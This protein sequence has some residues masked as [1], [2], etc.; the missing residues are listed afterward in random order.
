MIT[1]NVVLFGSI[2]GTLLMLAAR[3]SV[4]IGLCGVS[5]FDCRTMLDNIEHATYI[6]PLILLFSLITY[7]L[8]ETAFTTWWKFARIA[9]PIVIVLGFV[10]NLGLHHDP[11]GEFQ[12]IFDI[13][14]LILLYS[15]FIIGSAIQ[16]YR[17][18]R[19]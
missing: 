11:A 3:N 18:Y 2:I 8:P 5:D 16:I 9:A 4:D 14:A 1:K 7:K 12:N 17:G 10:I 15:V 6:F 13:P 19:R